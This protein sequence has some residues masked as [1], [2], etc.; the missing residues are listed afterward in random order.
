MKAIVCT[1][2]GPPEELELKEVPMPEPRANQI[3]IR[4]KAASVNDYD[5][6]LVRGKPMVY[7]L[8]FGLRR[9]RKP[10][11][12]MEVAGIVDALGP[13]ATRF[14]VGDDV[15]GDTSD[16]GFG[17]FAEYLCIHENAV[18]LKPEQLSFVAAAAVPHALS[19]AHQGLELGGLRPNMNVLINGAGGGV[20]TFALQ[21]AKRQGA[22]VTGVDTG[23]KLEQMRTLGFDHLVDYK[24]HDFTTAG[25]RYD[26]VLDTK[27]SR[28]PYSIKSALNE[29][30]VY[31]TVGG[32]PVR[33]IQILI[34]RLIGRK[35]MRILALKPNKGLA[36]L[37]PLLAQGLHP[38]LDG[39]HRLED[40][41][42]LIRYFGEGKHFGKVVV[43]V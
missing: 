19:L 31:V 26:L 17:S 20:G 39:P 10:I 14:K 7:R 16:H 15:Y 33:L 21:L 24:T 42:R 11:P 8:I 34:A 30:G 2:Y 35:N 40:I 18:I 5:W 32:D 25:M 27:S 9:P 29:G 38:I 3:R 6:S 37:H 22:T 43:E 12:G 4:V 23:E 28:S 13:G 41:P 36:E 1:H